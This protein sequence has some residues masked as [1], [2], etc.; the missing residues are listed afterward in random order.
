MRSWL[1]PN[2]GT[3]TALRGASESVPVKLCFESL[4]A[5]LD[6][7]ERWWSAV[8]RKQMHARLGAAY[9][10]R[11]NIFKNGPASNRRNRSEDKKILM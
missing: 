7:A 8:E 2:Q 9:P 4:L 10:S 3:S 11:R 6:A 5:G 1:L